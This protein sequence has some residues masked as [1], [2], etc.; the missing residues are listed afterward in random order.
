MKFY[1]IGIIFLFLLILS[2]GVVCA[3]DSNQTAQDTL[4]VDE[5]DVLGDG[6]GT[7]TELETK[8]NQST[9]SISLDKD[10]K[11][12]SSDVN[13]TYIILSKKNLTIDGNN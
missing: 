3:E 10:Y 7:Y 4:E 11:Y 8:L 5:V 9:G 6:V 1:K 12:D 2:M 13:K